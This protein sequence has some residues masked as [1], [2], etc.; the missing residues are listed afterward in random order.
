[1]M[2]YH[3]IYGIPSKRPTEMSSVHDAKKKKTSNFTM[4]KNNSISSN[5]EN[6][7]DAAENKK[8]LDDNYKL[9][10]RKVHFKFSQG[11]SAAVRRPVSITDFM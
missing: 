2:I 5:N 11:F 10:K 6:A 9:K 3:L 7:R 8:I 1:M 4:F